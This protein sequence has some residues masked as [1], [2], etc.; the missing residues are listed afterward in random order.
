MTPEVID[1]AP[2]PASALGRRRRW[3]VGGQLLRARVEV[4][5]RCGRRLDGGGRAASRGVV[6]ARPAGDI[7]AFLAGVDAREAELRRE[8]LQRGLGARLCRRQVVDG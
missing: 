3:R 4:V 2:P 6:A 1:A 8:L 5:L 7:A